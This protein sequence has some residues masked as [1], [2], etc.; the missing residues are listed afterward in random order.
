MLPAKR[1]YL[2]LLTCVLFCTTQA[3]GQ[4]YKLWYKQPAAVWEEALPI[5]NGRLGAMVFGGVTEEE[6]Q[7]NEETLWTGGPRQYNA[8]NAY[9]YLDSIRHLLDVGRQQEAEALAMQHF[10]GL[11]SD[12]EDPTAWLEKIAKLRDNENG[13]SSIAFDDSDWATIEV[14][15][16]E[17][18]ETIGL[19]AFDG[20][21]WFRREVT[22]TREQAAVHWVLDLNKIRQLDYTYVNGRLVGSKEGDETKREYTIP[23]GILKP[24]KNSIAIQVINF[25]GKGGIS[26]YKDT[27][28]H[29]GFVDN[30]GQRVAL[31]GQWKYYVQDRNVPKVGTYQAAYQPFGSLRFHFE[32]K[33][34]ADYSRELSLDDGKVE[35]NYSQED[36]HYTRRYIA[37]QPDQCIGMEMTSDREHSISFDVSFDSKH[38]EFQTWKINDSTVGLRVNVRNGVLSGVSIL[39]VSAPG[40]ELSVSDSYISVRKASRAEVYLVAATNFEDYR[41]F[42]ADPLARATSQLNKFAHKTFEQIYYDHKIDYEAL[43]SRFF[44]DLGF[45]GA[46]I[47]TD[48][49]LA[50]FSSRKTPYLVGL[51]LQYGRYL[52]IASSRVGTQPANLQGIWNHLLE[53]S[54]D[55]KYTSNINLEMNYWPTEVLNL[56][57]LH[58]PLFK[59][60]RELSVSG[61]ETARAYYNARGWVLH[62]NT[63]LWRGTAPINNSNHGIW[64]TG[65]AWLVSHLWES[66]LFQRDTS[67]LKEYYDVIKGATLFFKDVLVE[68]KSTGWLVSSPS[69]SPEHGGLVKGPTMD[70]QIVRHLFYVFSETAELLGRDTKLKD[71]IQTMIPQIAPNQIGKYG[72]L[73]EWLDDIDAP[74]NKHR[75]V[76]HLWGL[77]PGTEISWEHTPAFMEAAVKT[78][79]MRGDEGTGWSL[80]WKI[81]F[82]ARIRNAAHTWKML[83]MLLR[84]AG[85]SG[86]SYPNLFDAHPPFQIDGNFGGAAGIAEMLLQ[87][88]VGSIVLLPTLPS[89][90]QEGKVKGIRARGNFELQIQWSGGKLAKLRVYSGSGSPLRLVYGDKLVE[91]QTQAGITYDFDHE[92]T[93]MF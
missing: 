32:K 16:Y 12:S 46:S 45:D 52:Q 10:M 8:S 34:Y 36:T 75:H 30:H 18:W 69:N 35:V 28:Q 67:Q 74:E 42:S 5:G 71:S 86:G 49:L 85:R 33:P 3:Y 13:P 62:H 24:G 92:L 2:F 50:S 73:Q 58:Q 1:Y 77:H 63:D 41:H 20:V 84:P 23:P 4:E 81:N 26:G 78:L 90:L 91:M 15:H 7:F 39:K 40:G 27:T 6:I 68:D 48:E 31:Q 54:W 82:W 25:K 47:P 79:E 93:P 64:P 83:E 9:I 43:Y 56:G 29:I 53:P 72:Q 66:Y 22:L 55:S 17:G 19:E 38:Q 61:R 44:I 87:S 70:H 65:G 57:E 60:I 21:V 80:A 76:S 11:K 51:Y 59:M 89:Y 14:P 88:H 37:S